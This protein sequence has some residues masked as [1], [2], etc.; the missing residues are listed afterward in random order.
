MS[1]LVLTL[2]DINRQFDDY[3]LVYK[4]RD[5]NLATVWKEHF[6]TNFINSDH[7]IEK[8]YCLQGWQTEWESNYPRSLQ[9]LYRNN[10]PNN[11]EKRSSISEL[12]E[13]Q[14]KD[15]TTAKSSCNI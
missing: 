13:S 5:K 8:N 11:N 14:T 10:Q 6:Q 2:R 3:D 15:D 12:L 4:I 9:H 7:P 1:E